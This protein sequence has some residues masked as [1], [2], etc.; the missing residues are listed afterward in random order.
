M[1][2]HKLR[3][4]MT[5]IEGDAVKEEEVYE[6]LWWGLSKLKMHD[7]DDFNKMMMKVHCVVYGP[8][9]DEHAAKKAVEKCK[10]WMVLLVSIGALNNAQ[11]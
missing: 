2:M 4:Y 11:V 8:H 10:M 3:E 6:K 9:F 1:T 5:A 7:E